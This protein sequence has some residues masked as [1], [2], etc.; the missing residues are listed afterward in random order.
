MRNYFRSGFRFVAAA[1]ISLSALV[2]CTDYQDEINNLG[3]LYEDHEQRLKNLERLTEDF[4]SQLKSLTALVNAMEG[5]DYIKSVVPVENGYTIYFNK[6]SP[7]TITNGKDGSDG[8][9]GKTPDVSI[10]KDADGFYYWTLNGEWIL[11][12]GQKVRANAVDGEK[13]DKGDKG[14]QGDKGDKGDKG[15]SGTVGA[16]PLLRINA[17]TNEWEVSADGGKTWTTTGTKATGPKGDPGEKGD[18]GDKGD[19]ASGLF[20]DVKLS[21]DGKTLILTMTDGTVYNIPIAQKEDEPVEPE[22]K[23]IWVGGNTIDSN[24]ASSVGGTWLKKGKVSYDFE[25]KILTLENVEIETTLNNVGIRSE[26]SGLTIK[27]IGNCSVKSYATAVSAFAP[28]TITGAGVL[29]LE[30]S[31]AGIMM[32]TGSSV[33][34]SDADV[35][36]KGAWGITS[37]QGLDGYLKVEG[38]KTYLSAE[39]TS[40]SIADIGG[41]GLDG[42]KITVPESAVFDSFSG[43]VVVGEDAVKTLVEIKSVYDLSIGGDKVSADN[44]ASITGSWLKGG[45][46]S[47]EVASN[48][49]VLTNTEIVSSAAG[50]VSSIENL[51][52]RVNGKCSVSSSGTAIQSAGSLN[53]LGAGDLNLTSASGSGIALTENTSRLTVS[54][55]KVNASGVYGVSGV[56]D[57]LTYLTVTGSETEV[58]ATGS[59]GSVV[60]IDALDIDGLVISA[61]EGAKFDAA[62]RGVVKDGKIV[63]SKVVIGK[64]TTYDL[65]IG[66]VR[67]TAENASSITGSWYGGGS[68]SYSAASN[69]LTLNNATIQLSDETTIGLDSRIDGLKIYVSGTCSV[70]SKAPAISVS[71]SVTIIGGGVLNLESEWCGLSLTAKD[72]R[73]NVAKATVNVKGKWGIVG[74]KAYNAYLEL[75]DAAGELSAEGAEGSI[76]DIGGLALA[77]GCAITI[78]DGAVFDTARKAVVTSEGEVVKAKVRIGKK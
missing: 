78:P 37:R 10:R 69:L 65:W 53:I 76:V 30:G 25:T 50:I 39:G 15:D 48:T 38:T 52:I 33:T 26:V 44:A 19:G 77:D 64:K 54:G 36:V 11:S 32:Q 29:K 71:G 41:L 1:F 61:P 17:S 49:L 14:D 40:G 56:A 13:G 73:F 62:N 27:V 43:S 31:S 45:S 57:G 5:G 22:E 63:T 59:S 47:Y 12:G 28:M 3:K 6:Q 66:G 75:S 58:T 68:V 18:K 74:G 70:V 42:C 23:Y 2:S 51:K 46:V 16:V 60:N 7:I 55:G 20:A 8:A 24:N 34:I 4:T 9:D 67:V 72:S 21:E 35:R